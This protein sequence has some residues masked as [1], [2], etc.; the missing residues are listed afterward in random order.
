MT[1]QT[2]VGDLVEWLREKLKLKYIGDCKCGQCQLV[3]AALIE[4]AADALSALTIRAETA[5]RERDEARAT[6]LSQGGKP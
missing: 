2:P 5:E 6:V 1:N 4:E 3:E